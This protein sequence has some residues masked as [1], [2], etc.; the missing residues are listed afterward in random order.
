MNLNQNIVKK[1][2]GYLG[3]F[4]IIATLLPLIPTPMLRLSD[5]G[6]DH[7]PIFAKLSLEP[8]APVQ[9]EAPLPTA[10]DLKEAREMID[11]VQ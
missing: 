4:S 10:E 2:V 8:E 11:E 9:Q 5:I 6:S 3:V 1:A 7:F